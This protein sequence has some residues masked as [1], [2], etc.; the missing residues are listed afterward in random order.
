MVPAFASARRRHSAVT[1]RMIALAGLV[2]MVAALAF[3]S[4]HATGTDEQAT[5][6]VA[7]AA[8]ADAELGDGCATCGQQND[9]AMA[10]CL[11]VLVVAVLIASARRVPTSWQ[12]RVPPRAYQWVPKVVDR[13][14]R[15]QLEVLCIS[16][17]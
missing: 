9:G 11:M 13:P 3:G 10:A 5:P 14:S 2:A 6:G 4:L 7:H 16:R 12:A 15:P 1:A 8:M 17:T